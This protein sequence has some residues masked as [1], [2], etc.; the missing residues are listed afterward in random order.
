MGTNNYR[1]NTKRHKIQ[2]SGFNL[3]VNVSCYKIFNICRSHIYK[4]ISTNNYDCLKSASKQT[5]NLSVQNCNN[6][7]LF[8]FLINL[9]VV[10][11]KMQNIS[12]H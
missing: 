11:P 7:Y 6:K 2:K 4:K 12:D 9:L 3:L 8:F 10:G 5:K 1:L